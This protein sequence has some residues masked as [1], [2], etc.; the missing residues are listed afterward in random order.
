MHAGFRLCRP[1][2]RMS[3]KFPGG[4]GRRGVF[5]Q[6]QSHL[7]CLGEGEE[8]KSEGLSRAVKTLAEIHSPLPTGTLS[9]SLFGRS[10][11][12]RFS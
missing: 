4:A 5:L 12:R 3:F 11:G 2:G 7:F 10:P 6:V 9:R 1:S 8:S